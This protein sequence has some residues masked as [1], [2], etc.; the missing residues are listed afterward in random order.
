MER[1]PSTVD[2]RQVEVHL[3]P[4]GRMKLEALASEFSEH[5]SELADVVA[6]ARRSRLS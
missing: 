3:L 1:R 4:A 2:R 5:V 6:F